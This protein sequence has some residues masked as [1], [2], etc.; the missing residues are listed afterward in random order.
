MSTARGRT[1]YSDADKEEGDLTPCG[2]PQALKLAMLACA[3]A[4][5]FL[6]L[7]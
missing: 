5:Q 2:R 6:S 7:I 1:V 4:W 3:A